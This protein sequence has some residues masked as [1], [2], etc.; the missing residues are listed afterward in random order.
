MPELPEVEVTRQSFAERIHGARV[1]AVRLGKPLR[2]PL[3]VEPRPARRADGRRGDAARQ[4][5]VAAARP[6]RAADAPGHVGLARVRGR[7]R[8]HPGRTTTSI[9]SRRAARLR[10]TDPRRFGAV[11]WSPALDAGMA[12][13]LLA[14]LGR[15]ALRSRVHRRASARGAAPPARRRSRPRCWRRHRRRRRQHLR[16]RGAVRGRH[17]PAHALRPPQPRAL[18][19]AGRRRARRRWRA[20]WSWRL[21]AA[22]LSRRARHGRR[23]P[24]AGAG[25]RPRRASRAVRCGTTVRRIVQGQ[26]STFF[27]PGCQRR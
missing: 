20:R 25:L 10:L 27:C 6:R 8:P 12:A 19:S 7:C 22:R 2:W 9:W 16:L 13:K 15:R 18:R 14:G 4:V 24:A 5:S 21:D 26:R 17:R 11:V 1:T 3:G 23:V